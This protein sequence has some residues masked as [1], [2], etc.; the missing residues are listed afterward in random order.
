[1]FFFPYRL[2][3]NTHRWP[4]LTLLICILC[5]LI[6]W[7]QYSVDRQYV[8]ALKKFCLEDLS[9]RELAWLNRVPTQRRGNK[10]GFLLESIRETGDADA[11]IERLAALTR[12]IK[13]FAS[14]QENR[15]H[16]ESIL[17]EI[18]RK[19]EHDVPEPL[20][21]DLVYD[22]HDLDVIKMFTATFS[23]G[24]LT[25][26]VGNL[27]FFYIFAAAVEMALGSLVLLGFVIVTTLGTSLAYSYSMAGVEGALPTLGLSGVVMAAV[28]ALGVMLP[29]VRIRC[30]FWF[31]V[32]FRVLRIPA[33]LL[34]TWYV[35][36]DIYEINR[37]GTNAYVNYVAHL[38]GAAMGAT[39]GVY[40]L[41]FR[42]DMLEKLL[43]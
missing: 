25:H 3:A 10:C 29:S 24:S 35:G 21:R 2:D 12:P 27:L 5:A 37:L 28:A 31:L 23:H 14:E 33:L 4:V 13:L 38:S 18:Y 36:W 26:L 1:M 40:Y 22:P 8:Q 9:A 6:Y 32:F 15:A 30:F 7:Q 11:E 20:T 17:T 19:F 34:A 41:V 42:G 16:V 39:F 43:D